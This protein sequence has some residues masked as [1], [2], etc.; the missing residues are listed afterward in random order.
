MQSIDPFSI[1]LFRDG[2]IDCCI[3]LLE[4]VLE[5]PRWT[6]SLDNF[7]VILLCLASEISQRDTLGEFATSKLLRSVEEWM[8]TVS[9]FKPLTLYT[10]V[11]IVYAQV[12]IEGAS[13][14]VSDWTWRDLRAFNDNEAIASLL[15][16]SH[17]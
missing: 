9:G 12:S 15:P 13:V 17:L 2:V 14:F 6:S 1:L 8:Q 16:V 10:H 5:L 11:Q 4:C 7:C 3:V